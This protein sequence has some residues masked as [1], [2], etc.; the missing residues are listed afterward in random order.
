MMDAYDLNQE[1][2]RKFGLTEN[3][4]SEVKYSLS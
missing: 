1:Q 4:L 2:I 3:V